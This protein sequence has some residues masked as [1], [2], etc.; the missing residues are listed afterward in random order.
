MRE[1]KFP[2]SHFC[3][4]LTDAQLDPQLIIEL[5][6]L[7]G[8]DEVA[9]AA[10]QRFGRGGHDLIDLGIQ[11]L[12]VQFLVIGRVLLQSLLIGRGVHRG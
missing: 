8:E 11:F 9:L 12:F 4:V 10:L 3:L 1:R 5:A 2:F 6:G 7:G